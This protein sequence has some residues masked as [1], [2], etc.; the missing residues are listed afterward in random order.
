MAL[1]SL[2]EIQFSYGGGALLDDVTLQI[3][4]GE[5]V[6]L[7]GRNGSGKSTLMKLISGEL[8]PDNGQV[9]RGPGVRIGRLIQ[10]V[11]I[12]SES[13]VH[14]VVAAGLAWPTWEGEA[15]AEPHEPWHLEQQIER[16]L[17]QMNLDPQARFAELSSG[18]KRRVLLAQALVSQPD[19][20]CSTN[21]PTT[22][23]SKRSRGWKSS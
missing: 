22:W 20:C 14:E 7:V 16:V 10:E 5:R 19:C 13:S 18:M 15:P 3:E 21:R 17:S 1:V 2:N 12:G 11:P 23:T 6:G 9:V 4:R 8:S